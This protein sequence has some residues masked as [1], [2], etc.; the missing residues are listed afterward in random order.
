MYLLLCS[1][2]PPGNILKQSD[3]SGSPPGRF[4]GN[5]QL[6]I[7]V[8]IGIGACSMKGY[9]TARRQDGKE[10]LKPRELHK[11]LLIQQGFAP[12]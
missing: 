6:P 10:P 3:C 5:G 12:F 1:L 7:A 11:A 8:L 2:D 9:V 4:W